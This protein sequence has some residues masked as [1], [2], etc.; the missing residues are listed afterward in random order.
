MTSLTC[1]HLRKILH[2]EPATG[3]FTHL[4]AYPKSRVEVGSIAGHVEKSGYRRIKIARRHYP[5]HRLAWLY[6]YGEWPN[7]QVDHANRNPDDNRIENLRIATRSQNQG[8]SVKPRHGAGS[9]RGAHFNRFKGRW[10]AT[11]RLNG[12]T[13]FLGYF[14]SEELAHEA[15]MAAAKAKYGPFAC[16][17]TRRFSE[18]DGASSA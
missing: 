5:A 2:Y 17:V 13:K 7:G 3:V 11:I 14:A 15:Y 10:Q 18:E 6:V 4:I 8:N 1:D 16:A 12:K 9:S